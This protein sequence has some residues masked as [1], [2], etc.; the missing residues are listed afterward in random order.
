[1]P[2]FYVLSLIILIVA[3]RKRPAHYDGWRRHA[4]TIALVSATASLLLLPLIAL[5]NH[6]IGPFRRGPQN[7]SPEERK[8]RRVDAAKREA[9][10]KAELAL[11][12][13]M[14]RPQGYIV[15]QQVEA[16]IPPELKENRH[17]IVNA[18]RKISESTGYEYDTVAQYHKE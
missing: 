6:A 11:L 1:M 3:W 9:D 14:G 2:V 5:L 7:I 4:G 15:G 10:R 8:R 13:S 17:A 18:R 16:L 12:D